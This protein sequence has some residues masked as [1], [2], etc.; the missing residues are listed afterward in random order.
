MRF[1]PKIIELGVAVLVR[2]NSGAEMSVTFAL[3]VLFA[4]EGSISFPATVAVFVTTPSN[5]AFGV[6]TMLTS[7]TPP[8]G[9][10]PNEQ[11]TVV[12]PEQRP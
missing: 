4:G 3:A 11:V 5:W 1:D 7:A 10:T 2:T 12:V 6:T 9:I 8:L